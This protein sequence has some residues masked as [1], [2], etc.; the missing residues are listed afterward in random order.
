VEDVI[1]SLN[2]PLIRL[3]QLLRTGTCYG[4]LFAID[5]YTRE[6]IHPMALAA[7]STSSGPR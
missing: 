2:P 4:E 1:A 7:R 5:E 3:G 6:R